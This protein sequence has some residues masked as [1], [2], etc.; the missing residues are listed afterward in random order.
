MQRL[1]LLLVL[2]SAVPKP[3]L[4]SWCHFWRGRRS[5]GNVGE[6]DQR[7]LDGGGLPLLECPPEQFVNQPMDH[8]NVSNTALWKQVINKTTICSNIY[9]IASQKAILFQLFQLCARRT[10]FCDAFRRKYGKSKVD[11]ARRL[12]SLC[13]RSQGIVVPVGASILW[14]KSTH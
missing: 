7:P 11:V 3:A 12:D 9:I 8:F 6:P 14:Q 13:K 1:L 2:L 4:G 5:T 10:S